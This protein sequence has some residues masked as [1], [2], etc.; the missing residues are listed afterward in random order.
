MT[1]TQAIAALDRQLLRHGEGV[2]ILAVVAGVPVEPGVTVRGFV[3]G[4]KPEDLAGG[5]VKQADRKVILSPTGLPG[6]PAVNSKVRISG[7][8]FNVEGSNP[9]RLNNELVR[10]ELQVRG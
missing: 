1:P 6:V 2:T 8:T 7:K 9:T 5:G 3:R 10:I 4:Y